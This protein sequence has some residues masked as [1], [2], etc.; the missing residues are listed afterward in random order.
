MRLDWQVL[1]TT[2]TKNSTQR[3]QIL[4]EAEHPNG[5]IYV[6]ERDKINIGEFLPV[7]YKHQIERFFADLTVQNAVSKGTQT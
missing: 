1:L 2:Q 4:P 6:F 7:R 3:L 5:T